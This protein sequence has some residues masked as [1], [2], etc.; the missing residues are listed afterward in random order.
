MSSIKSSPIIDRAK[1]EVTDFRSMFE[2]LEQKGN[3]DLFWTNCSCPWAAC[4]SPIENGGC[5]LR[6]FAW[7][8]LIY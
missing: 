3:F 4:L 1:R 2:R 8:E 7:Q 6:S 5:Y